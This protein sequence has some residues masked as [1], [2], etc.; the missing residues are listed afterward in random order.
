MASLVTVGTFLSSEEALISQSFLDAHG[1]VAFVHD[2]HLATNAWHFTH[3]IQGVR[4]SVPDTDLVLARQLLAC[5]EPVETPPTPLSLRSVAWAIIAYFMV[6]I[7]HPVS[8]KRVGR[9]SATADD[10]TAHS[11]EGP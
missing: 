10:D 1:V 7:P 2:W 5:A 11:P 9:P 8:R 6:G 3:A 4:L